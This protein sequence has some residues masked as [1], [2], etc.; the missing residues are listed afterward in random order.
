MVSKMDYDLSYTVMALAG[1]LGA[2]MT[3]VAIYKI[4]ANLIELS[5]RTKKES[6][7]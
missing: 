5:K 1:T 2:A 7:K 3:T 6:N 4:I